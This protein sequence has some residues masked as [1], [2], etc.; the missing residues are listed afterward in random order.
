MEHDEM[1]EG[2]QIYIKIENSLPHSVNFYSFDIIYKF[3]ILIHQS[4]AL[5]HFLAP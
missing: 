5:I 3:P 4:T 1:F 2:K